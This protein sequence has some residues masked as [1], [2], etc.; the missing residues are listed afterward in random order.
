[1][2]KA[3]NVSVVAKTAEMLGF[4]LA[5]SAPRP[6]KIPAKR[7]SSNRSRTCAA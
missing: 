4:P 7:A 6:A 5:S 3:E 1:M 2:L